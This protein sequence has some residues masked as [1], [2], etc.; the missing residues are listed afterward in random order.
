VNCIE[1][2]KKNDLPVTGILSISENV[3]IIILKADVF[4]SNKI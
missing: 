3:A 2:E 4:K 1:D